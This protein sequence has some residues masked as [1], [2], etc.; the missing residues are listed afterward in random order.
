M[1]K[2]SLQKKRNVFHYRTGTLLNQKHAVRFRMSTSLQCPLCQRADSALHVCSGCQHIIISGM[3]TERHSVACRLII[4]AISKSSQASCL[5]HLDAG[6]TDWP[7]TKFNFLSML[8]TGHYPA[9]FS[10][11]VY[12]LEIESPLVAL[13]PPLPTKNSI[14]NHSSFA[15]GVTSK[16]TQ[17]RCM[18]SSPAQCQHEGDTP[19]WGWILWRY[20][21][22][23]PF[24]GLQKTTQGSF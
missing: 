24:K 15:P 5:I 2:L 11:L 19:R 4:K 6:S 12:M 21:A 14:A 1:S 13:M 10:M 17:Q 22:W 16:T 18:Q 8:I 7:N 20:T 23:I 3:I 9:G